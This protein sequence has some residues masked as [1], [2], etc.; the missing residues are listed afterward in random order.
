MTTEQIVNLLITVVIPIIG[1][2]VTYLVWPFIKQKT[3]KAQREEVEYW[4][5][6][7]VKA[8]E[9]LAKD[10]RL[11]I[12]KKDHVLAYINAKGFDITMDDLDVILEALVHELNLEKKKVE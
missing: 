11:N 8:A 10:G 1:A 4:V 6:K 12:P 3:T 9:Q 2:L 5:G 7:A